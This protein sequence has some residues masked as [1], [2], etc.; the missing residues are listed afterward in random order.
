M[1]LNPFGNYAEQFK[2]NLEKY[3]SLIQSQNHLTKEY[4][5]QRKE[6]FKWVEEQIALELKKIQYMNPAEIYLGT[7]NMSLPQLYWNTYVLWLEKVKKMYELD[8]E[9]FKN[10]VTITN[11]ILAN[12]PFLKGYSIFDV[13]QYFNFFKPLDK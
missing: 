6:S 13:F 9:Y 7:V 10:L 11:P 4:I 2:A 8:S 3:E 12:N 5:E 1:F